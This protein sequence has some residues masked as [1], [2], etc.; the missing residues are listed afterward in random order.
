MS[1]DRLHLQLV[2]HRRPR[3]RLLQL[4]QQPGAGR[5]R[6]PAL[7]DLGHRAVGL[8]G[9]RPDHSDG[10]TTRLRAAPPGH[11]PELPHVLEQQAGA[12][13]P[14]R[15]QTTRLRARS[16]APRSLDDAIEQRIARRPAR[17]TLARAD[18]RDGGRRHASTC[19]AARCCRWMLEVIG[20]P[21]EPALAD[22]VQDAAALGRRRARTAA[23]RTRDGALRR[24]ARGPDHGRL[25]AARASRPMFKPAL[26][27]DSR[28]VQGH[29][30]ARRRAAQPR[31]PPRQRL[32]GRLV[33]LRRRRT[34]A[35]CSAQ[36]V[37][38]SRSR[39]SYCGNGDARQLPHALRG[40]LDALA[41]RRPSREDSSTSRQR[42]A[43]ARRPAPCA[44]TRSASA[45]SARSPS[46]R[47]LDQPP[48]LPAGGRGPGPPAALSSS[49][50]RRPMRRSAPLTVRPA[51]E[52]R[53]TR[54]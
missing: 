13:L 38:G 35:R 48:D 27:H 32:P 39:A 11:Q 46:A 16:T 17:S 44:T 12:R 34:C 18:R 25:V 4:R 6:G 43:P 9:L 33:R 7:P 40:S 54:P 5:G 20:T 2:L 15:R 10:A 41:P 49:Q 50:R 24:R 51:T 36:P 42:R 53:P 14:R 8:A 31:R 29:D 26:G 30:G 28:R 23:T 21:S 52:S 47:S 19:A 1:Q 45:R 22:A 37:P 3:H